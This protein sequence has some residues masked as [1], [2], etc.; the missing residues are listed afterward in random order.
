MNDELVKA[1]PI[2]KNDQ[3]V[4]AKPNNKSEELLYNLNKAL[5]ES[6]DIDMKVQNIF[7][8]VTGTNYQHNPTEDREPPVGAFDKFAA[9][10]SDINRNLQDLNEMLYEIQLQIC[11]DGPPENKTIK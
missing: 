4:K 8:D 1:K 2:N 7:Q 5:S 3:L 6:V 11:L 10:V 9:L